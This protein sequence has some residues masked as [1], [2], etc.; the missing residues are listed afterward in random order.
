MSLDHPAI[1]KAYA[2]TVISISDENGAV[3]KD[4]KSVSL[5]SSLV[6]KARTEIDEEYAKVKYKDDRKPLYPPLEDF[7]DAMY[8]NSKGDS[9]KLT[10]YYAA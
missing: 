1:Y 4:G 7:A 8:W 6:A 5:D 10:A 9:S 3:D 2:G